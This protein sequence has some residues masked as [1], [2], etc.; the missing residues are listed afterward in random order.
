MMNTQA[1]I[2]RL[3]LLA[4]CLALGACAVGPDYAAPAPVVGDGWSQPPAVAGEPELEAWWRRLGDPELIRLVEAA[5]TANLDL[6]QA[7]TRVAEAR[8]LRDAAGAGHLPVVEANGSVTRRRWSENGAFPVDRIPGFERDQTIVDVGFDASWELDLFGRVRRAVEAADARLGQ[9]LAE[10]GAVELVVTAEIARSYLGLRGLQRELAANRAAV[11]AAEETLEFVRKRHAA[12]AADAQQLAQTQAEVA[13]LRA[14]LPEL[15]GQ[16]RAT[17]LA[18]GVLTG[19]LPE[20]ELN[21]AGEPPPALP[22]QPLPV[23][24]RADL[25][26]RRP[27]VAA[28]ERRLAA[29]TAEVGLATAELYPRL[30]V[31]AG[32]GFEALDGEDLVSRDSERW[33]LTPFISWRLFDG[34]RIRA[35]IRASDARLQAAGLAWE[36]SVL[37][38]LGDAEQALVRYRS[39]LDG[40]ALQSEAVAAARRNVDFAE[41][42][43]RAGAVSLLELLDSRRSLYA[44]EDAEARVH[45]RAATALVSLYKALGGGWQPP[46]ELASSRR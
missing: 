2:P 31:S 42:R 37:E 26:G 25:L 16:V 40:L 23:G 39:A 18:I 9:R 10:Q 38:A 30:A 43:Y 19:G 15:E 4:A 5:R 32:G 20:S 8:A 35:R 6:R 1:F 46:A 17:A 12:G 36:Q 13:A 14:T 33:A 41:T 22:L 11:G 45:T 44:A 28:A 21:L 3:P 29:A 34:G 27:D 24:E 7:M